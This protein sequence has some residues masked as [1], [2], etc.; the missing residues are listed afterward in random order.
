LLVQVPQ[1]V[2]HVA[3]PAAVEIRA[4]SYGVPILGSLSCFDIL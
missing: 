3:R 2:L 4:W 1:Q